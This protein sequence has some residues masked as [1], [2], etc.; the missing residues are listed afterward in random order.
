MNKMLHTSYVHCSDLTF[1]LV[2]L[3][4]VEEARSLGLLGEEEADDE[5]VQHRQPEHQGR[6]VSE[7]I[8]EQYCVQSMALDHMTLDATDL[9]SFMKKLVLS[10]T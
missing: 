4:A 10:Q 2:G 8:M 9:F 6:K 1:P 7:K 5:D 3:I